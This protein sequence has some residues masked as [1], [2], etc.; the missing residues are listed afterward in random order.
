MQQMKTC[1][2]YFLFE[3]TVSKGKPVSSKNDG[4]QCVA[5]TLVSA[6]SKVF[7]CCVQD[8]KWQC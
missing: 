1:L 8:L 6:I 7:P 4:R 3:L 5:D 2:P